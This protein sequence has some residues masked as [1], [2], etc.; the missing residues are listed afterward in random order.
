M[1]KPLINQ[2]FCAPKYGTGQKSCGKSDFLLPHTKRRYIVCFVFSMA[3][4]QLYFNQFWRKSKVKNKYEMVWKK[5]A[6][7][8]QMRQRGIPAERIHRTRQSAHRCAWQRSD[9]ILLLLPCFPFCVNRRARGRM[10]PHRAP[11]AL[12][13]ATNFMRDNPLM[14]QFQGKFVHKWADLFSSFF[15]YILTV[16]VVILIYFLQNDIIFIE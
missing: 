13:K 12:C 6:T 1:P 16:F 7:L 10:P 3:Y 2:Y 8:P 4:L 9:K 11:G 15:S 14:R 5:Y